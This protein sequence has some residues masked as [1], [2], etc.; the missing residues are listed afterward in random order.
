MRQEASQNQQ[1]LETATQTTLIQ[2]PN[3]VCLYLFIFF[4]LASADQAQAQARYV[5]EDTF[6]FP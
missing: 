4:D 1:S 6:R 3:T 2:V 5:V